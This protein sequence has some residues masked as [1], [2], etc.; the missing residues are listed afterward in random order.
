VTSLDLVL[1]FDGSCDPNPG[2][3]PSYGWH[4]DTVEGERVA[5][6]S[7]ALTY[8]PV[9]QRTNNT[10]EFAALRAGLTWI[11]AL[12]FVPVDRLVVVGDS[13]LVVQVIS[14]KWKAKKPHLWELAADC[15]HLIEQLDVGHFEIKWVRR[16][17]NAEA[18]RLASY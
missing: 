13:Q 18:D 10:A 3:I 9:E 11:A 4:L 1:H 7:G 14:G 17:F 2:G 6:G 15:R 8:L 16:E 12:Q 5:Q